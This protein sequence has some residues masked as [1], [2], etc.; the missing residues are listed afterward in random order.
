M[1]HTL[2]TVL[3]KENND[4]LGRENKIVSVVEHFLDSSLI[5]QIDTK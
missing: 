1:I 4:L 2:C 3:Y 5:I